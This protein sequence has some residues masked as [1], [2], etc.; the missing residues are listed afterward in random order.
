MCHMAPKTKDDC[1]GKDKQQFTRHSSQGSRQKNIVMGTAG[2]RTKNNCT[3]GG[4]QHVTALLGA[5][6]CG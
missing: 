5:T 4:Q 2:P 1:A 6:V 3:W